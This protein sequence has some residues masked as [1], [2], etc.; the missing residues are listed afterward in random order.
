MTEPDLRTIVARA[1]ER[2]ITDGKVGMAAY[3]SDADAVLAALTAAGALGGATLTEDERHALE[4]VC[5]AEPE[6]ETDVEMVEWSN[7]IAV[8]RSL[9][10][11]TEG[12]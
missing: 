12:A 9:L 1:L 3:D 11:R 7:T 10:D 2:N 6:F 8:L 4:W 5:F